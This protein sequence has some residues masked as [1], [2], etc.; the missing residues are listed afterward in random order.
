MGLKD[1]E[2]NQ[3]TFDEEMKKVIQESKD[4]N[5]VNAV[6]NKIEENGKK[7]ANI[8]NQINKEKSIENDISK[9]ETQLKSALNSNKVSTNSA[10][11]KLILY[12]K[13]EN[14]QYKKCEK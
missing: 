7:I 4:Q 9:Q 6:K 2:K 10:S 14:K 8:K 5:S 12:K 13:F 11:E 3:A 1:L